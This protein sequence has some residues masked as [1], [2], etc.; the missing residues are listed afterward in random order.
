M[1]ELIVLAKDLLYLLLIAFLGALLIWGI[2]HLIM[3]T[4]KTLFC[5][6]QLKSYLIWKKNFK[7]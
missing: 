7:K 3:A 6:V 1:Q 2:S 5:D 4:I